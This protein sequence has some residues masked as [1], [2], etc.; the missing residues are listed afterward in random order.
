MEIYH[1]VFIK[2]DKTQINYIII[3]NLFIFQMI[4]IF[5]SIVPLCIV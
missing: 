4:N 5:E 3:C 2:V 1:V